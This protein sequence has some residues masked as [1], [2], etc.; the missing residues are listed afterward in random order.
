VETRKKDEKQYFFDWRMKDRDNPI[1]GAYH[2][3]IG[4]AYSAAINANIGSTFDGKDMIIWST[5]SK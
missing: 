4:E 1:K 2:S 3:M 5:V